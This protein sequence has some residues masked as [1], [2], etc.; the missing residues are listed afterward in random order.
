MTIQDDIRE[1][2]EKALAD[3]RASQDQ[4]AAISSMAALEAL[5]ARMDV[6]PERDHLDH[7]IL[8]RRRGLK[9]E[10]EKLGVASDLFDKAAIPA[11][12]AL[13]GFLTFLASEKLLADGLRAPV[14]S[15]AYLVGAALWMFCRWKSFQNARLMRVG[16]S[17]L[18]KV[19]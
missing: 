14:L 6:G 8:S 7:L 15:G 3:R 10:L 12:A 18:G 11:A 9:A 5:R 16:A 19:D 17:E 1:D 2:S 4:Y 13:P